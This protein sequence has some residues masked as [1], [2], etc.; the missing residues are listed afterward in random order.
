MPL[1]CFELSLLQALGSCPELDYCPMDHAPIRAD[2]VYRLTQEEGFMPV[3][4]PPGRPLRTGEF[5]G[6]QLLHMAQLMNLE[7]TAAPD[8]ETLS[9]T[10]RLTRLL[11]QPLLGSRPLSSRELFRQV[12]SES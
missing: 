9:A 7:A 12:Y 10:K 6:E 2:A 4:V 8:S 11:L 5:Q 1:R 3:V